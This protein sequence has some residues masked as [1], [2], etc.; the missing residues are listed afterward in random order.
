MMIQ[1]HKFGGMNL[2]VFH[3]GCTVLILIS[4]CLQGF[5]TFAQP[6]AISL[7]SADT[8]TTVILSTDMRQLVKDKFKEDYQPATLEI[9]RG[10]GDTVTYQVEVRSRGNIRKEV[11]YYPPVFVRFPKTEYR[12]HK[13]KWVN[14]CRDTDGNETYLLKEFLAYK[15]LRMLTDY[16][17]DARLTRV[18]YI[19]TGRDGKAF[20]R[21]A[22]MIQHEEE[23][24]ASFGG[25]NY[26][27]KLLKPELL[28]P[29]QMALFTFFQYMIGNTDWAYG[30]CHNV[31]V[32]THPESGTLI[33][34]AYDFDYSGLV[35]TTYAVP[36]ETLPIKEVSTR[37][38]KGYCIDEDLCEK[39][40]LFF[41]SRKE[42]IYSYCQEFSP[43]HPKV[44]EDVTGY[45]DPFF[46]M[47]ESEKQTQRVFVRDCGM[48]D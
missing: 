3:S 30:N 38:N 26:E 8:A 5:S 10:M 23:M 34:V 14:C 9:V 40:R 20:T 11:C 39:M 13:I 43:L 2:R 35:N 12:F 28:N 21:Y 31:M 33:P 41:L 48:M 16:S 19:D 47:L 46:K 4:C 24:A 45:L 1:T 36:H 18:T 6:S 29:E 7:F 44:R 27:P 37:H 17:L 32:F 25:R 22:F 15:M 42:A